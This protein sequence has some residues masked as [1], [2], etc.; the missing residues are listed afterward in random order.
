[1]IIAYNKKLN[2]EYEVLQKFKAGI[3]LRGYEV[4]AIR[5]KKVSFEG[6]SVVVLS[7]EAFVV[8][9]GIGR[10]SHQSQKHSEEDSRRTR[11]LLLNKSEILKLAQAINEKGC[12]AVP[13]ALI[14]EKNLIK[15]EVAVVR[16][17]KK[18]EKKQ[19]LI[20]RQVER[21][22]QRLNKAY[23]KAH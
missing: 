11:K 16:R 5:E 1:M 13:A 9:F 22:L 2:L 8:N 21:D 3:S 7:G 17:K 14:L 6:A 18:H 4:K 15:L 20:S 19:V 23:F 10:Y 12:F